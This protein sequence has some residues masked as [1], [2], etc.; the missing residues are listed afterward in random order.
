MERITASRAGIWPDR[1]AD[2]GE[3]V[4]SAAVHLPSAGESIPGA[5][6]VAGYEVLGELGH[7]GMGVV[8]RVR[9][10]SLNRLV[11]L[12]IMRPGSLATGAELERFHHEAKAL[13]ELDHPG[14]VP[15]LDI[16]EAD[17]RPYFTMKLIEGG[18]LAGCLDHFVGNPRLAVE[19][20]VRIA[21]AVHHAN[22]RGILHRDLKPSNVLLDADGRPHITD[23]GLARHLV[24]DASLTHSREVLG[25]PGYMAPEQASC[26]KRSVSPAIDVYGLG[27]IFYTLLTRRQPFQ[28]ATVLDVLE[29]VKSHDPDPPSRSN[30]LVKRDLEA[31]CLKC[32]E[33]EPH[34]RY[35]SADALADDLRRWL[36]GQPT[37]AR[38]LG[39]A[40]RAWRWCRRNPLLGA[41]SVVAAVALG[42]ALVLAVGF[43]LLSSSAAAGLRWEQEQ[44]QVQLKK[45]QRLSADLALGKALSLS[46]QGEVARGMLW[47]AHSL[48]IA[49]DAGADDL[50]RV[51][52][53]NLAGWRRRLPPLRA[54]LPHPANVNAVAFSP[55]GRTVLTGSRDGTARFW[56]ATTGAARAVSLHHPG[57]VVAVA[58]CPKDGQTVLTGSTDGTAR[59]WDVATGKELREFPGHEREVRAVAFSP[60]GERVLTA[61]I[62]KTA[63]LWDAGTGECLHRLAHEGE[64][65]AAAFSPDGKTVLTGGSDH[66]ARLWEVA[67]GKEIRTFKGHWGS[68]H[69]VAFRP[70]GKT[71]LTGGADLTA[72]LWDVATGDSLVLPHQGDVWGVA[73]S[74]DGKTILTGGFDRTARLWD[75]D[76]AKIVG[77][78]LYHQSQVWA[79]AFSPDGHVLLTGSGK[80]Q[81]PSGEARLYEVPRGEAFRDLCNHPQGVQAAAFSPDGRRVLTGGRDQTAR[82]WEAATGKE[83][84]PFRG[85]GGEVVAVA[86]RHDGRAIVTGSTDGTARLWDVSS[87]AEVLKL[88]GHRGEVRAAAFS[89]DGKR[90]LTG[91]YDDTVRLWSAD[92]GKELH[93]LEGP[94]EDLLRIRAVAF[95]PDGKTVLT[96]GMGGTARVWDVPTGKLL[97]PSF[98]HQDTITAAAFGPDS[99]LVLT[100]SMDGTA[101]LR[102]AATGNPS[103]PLLPH[104][105]KVWAVAFSPDG[106][107]VA[108]GGADG[109]TRLWDAD[110][111]I[112]LGPLLRQK[113]EVRA[114]AFNPDGKTILAGSLDGTVRQWE[115]AAPL[116]GDAERIVLWAQVIT[117]KELGPYGDALWLD[118]ETWH[119]RKQ[120]LHEV[121]GPPP[122]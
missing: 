99:R 11:A 103:T 54:S 114:V 83:I 48:E 86:W 62:D 15:I 13:A 87:G 73:F 52:R 37:V 56:D 78:P 66:M 20:L 32:L 53:L 2:T 63:R 9:Q 57:P 12:K 74:P 95:S 19:V 50:E 68:V 18:S 89:P 97:G 22:A 108:T 35:A 116:Q 90:V 23:F 106:R 98:Q 82:L 105:A 49:T 117:G 16:G 122:P 46:E 113:L 45:A 14:I 27:A 67:T 77:T 110:T 24:A 47:L 88:T 121:G 70:R 7:G 91:S 64:V 6:K 96:G 102:D 94:A 115:M 29:Q 60:D 33:K 10:Q 75:A 55:D 69:A 41:V 26:P 36:S 28:G 104:Q 30:R 111:G 80:P 119:Q 34:R 109:A 81:A 21:D 5:P 1:G 118:A 101:G 40:G 31:I 44:T 100:G 59:L 8:Y 120:R 84:H 38:P 112:R 42:A 61:S 65:W 92:T 76:T 51:I 79:V 25:T 17:G 85:H 71:I 4:D 3:T 58:F 39:P 107:T 43:V 72:R 93:R